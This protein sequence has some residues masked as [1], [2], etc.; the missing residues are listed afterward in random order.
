LKEFCPREV[1]NSDF[2]LKEL[3]VFLF[4]FCCVFTVS[5]FLKGKKNLFVLILKT[6]RYVFIIAVRKNIPKGPF[7][8]S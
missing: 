1:K 6:F 5:I 7:P 2:I 4:P 3:A 8:L